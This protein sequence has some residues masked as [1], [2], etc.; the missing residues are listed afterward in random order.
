M[1]GKRCIICKKPWEIIELYEGIYD[2]EMIMVCEECANEEKIPIL[3]KPSP[4]Q[5]NQA[6]KRYSVRERMEKM[7]GMHRHR[8]GL[9]K[10]QQIVQQNINRLKMPEPKQTH[11]DVVNNY[12]WELNMAR[13]RK[14]MTLNQVAIKTNV[15]LEALEAIEKGKIPKGF[16]QIFVRLEDFFGI[17]LLKH[18]KKRINYII[19]IE[20]EEE[21][22]SEVRRKMETRVVDED[23]EFEELDKRQKETK[24]SELDDGELD[25]SDKEKLDEITLSDLV[26]LKK[27]KEQKEKREK[28]RQQTEE[29]IGDDIDIIRE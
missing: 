3:R 20:E 12:Y 21:I 29:F 26:E 17:K 6:E 2:N 14:K 7:S 4:D 15:P 16:E 24:L 28:L 13:R 9:S 23:P 5:L 19:P 18:H 25:F 11:E 8:T 27:Q 1:L 22:L 10:D